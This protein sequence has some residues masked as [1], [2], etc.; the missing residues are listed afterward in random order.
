[1]VC[2]CEILYISDK[3]LIKLAQKHI[4]VKSVA[5]IPIPPQQSR[6]LSTFTD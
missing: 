3:D 1:L 5:D 6:L 2:S 4:R